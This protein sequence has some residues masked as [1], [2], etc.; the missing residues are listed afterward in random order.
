MR[1]QIGSIGLLAV[2]SMSMFAMAQ[3]AP[4]AGQNQGGGSSGGAGVMDPARFK[5]QILE[6]IKGQLAVSDDEWAKLSVKIEKVLDAQRQ[7]RTG[8][9]MSFSSPAMVNGKG[10]GQ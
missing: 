2:M 5:L 8:A 10:Q 3:P 7:T 1:T 4:R 9:G 6:G